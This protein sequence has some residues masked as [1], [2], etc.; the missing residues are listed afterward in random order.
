MITTTTIT[1]IHSVDKPADCAGDGLGVRV[2]VGVGVT[3][4]VGV[5]D[6]LG[7]GETVVGVNIAT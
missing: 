5:G 1:T 4:D 7:D 2:A 3:V 6:G